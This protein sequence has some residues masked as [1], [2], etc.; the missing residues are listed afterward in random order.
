[1]SSARWFASIGLLFA[2]A[3]GASGALYLRSRSAD[4]DAHARAVEAIGIVR[5]LDSLLSEHVLA[6]RFGLLNQ[7]DPLTSTELELV[8]AASTVHRRVAVVGTTP[9]IERALGE[10]DRAIAERRGA[11]EHFKA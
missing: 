2:L 11:L 1:M 7:Y 6:A 8:E 10:L 3:F 5:H 9:D 4:F